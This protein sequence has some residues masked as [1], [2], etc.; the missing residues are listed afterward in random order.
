MMLFRLSRSSRGTRRL[1]MNSTTACF[2]REK[3]T[4]IVMT[5]AVCHNT[6]NILL[7]SVMVRD[8]NSL[9]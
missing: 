4:A 3:K 7:A 9:A 1:V 6:L 2:S 8:H 5:N